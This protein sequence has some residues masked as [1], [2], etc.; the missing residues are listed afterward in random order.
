MRA[1]THIQ[2]GFECSCISY[3]NPHSL[4]HTY[5]KKGSKKC[6]VSEKAARFPKVYKHSIDS[7]LQLH[8]CNVVY[9]SFPLFYSESVCSCVSLIFYWYS[10]QFDDLMSEWRNEWVRYDRNVEFLWYRSHRMCI[11]SIFVSFVCW[12]RAKSTLFSIK[13]LRNYGEW[14]GNFPSIS[15]AFDQMLNFSVS[16]KIDLQNFYRIFQCLG[17]FI[18]FFFWFIVAE[19]TF[20]LRFYFILRIKVKWQWNAMA[21]FWSFQWK[22][23]LSFELYDTFNLRN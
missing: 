18:Y 15:K 6:G 13:H 20:Y 12:T 17:F 19:T 14:T 3:T 9:L 8:S 1:P 16:T 21:T 7:L 5:A 10:S 2:H 22:V 4:T 23:Y 11:A